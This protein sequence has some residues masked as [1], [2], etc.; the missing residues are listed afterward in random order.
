MGSYGQTW[1]STQNACH[2]RMGSYGA[3][4]NL[5]INS[6]CTPLFGTLGRHSNQNIIDMPFKRTLKCGGSPKWG[7]SL[8][9]LMVGLGYESKCWVRF[10]SQ[11]DMLM[12][13]IG[14][15]E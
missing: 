2:P 10:N 14:V 12:N 15:G 5:L 4:Q 11:F 9:H 7:P 6:K 13:C 1:P 3:W 8:D